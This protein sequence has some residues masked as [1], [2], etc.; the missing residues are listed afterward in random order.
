MELST[1]LELPRCPYCNINRPNLELS[2]DFF[3][4]NSHNNSNLRVW[5]IYI[6]ANC[7][8]VVLAA[9]PDSYFGIVEI[10]PLSISVDQ[11]IPQKAHTFLTQALDSISAPSGAV[12]LAGSAVDAMLKQKNYLD[13]SLYSRIDKAAKDHLI[14]DEMAKWAHEVRL[15]ANDQRHADD[16]APLPNEEDAKRI[17]DFALALAEYLFVLPSKIQKGRKS[18]EPPEEKK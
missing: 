18:I 16:D 17:L 12:M 9:K 5:G 11:S 4:T 2:R 1:V 6:C 13:G 10:Y 8:G 3:T 15:E 7:G 14:T